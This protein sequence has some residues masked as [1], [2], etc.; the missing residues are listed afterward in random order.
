MSRS[1]LFQNWSDT[2]SSTSGILRWQ[3]V[4]DRELAI[5][6][7][8]RYD[9]ILT[10]DQSFPSEVAGLDGHPALIV[11]V[12]RSHRLTHVLE[13]LPEILR[14]LSIVEPGQVVRLFRPPSVLT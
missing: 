2:L 9:A 13:L 6:A 10:L 7:T 1:V 5:R 4:P 8:G 14:T 3:S 12:S 11:L